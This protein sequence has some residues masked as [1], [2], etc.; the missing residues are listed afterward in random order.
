MYKH[1]RQ[2]PYSCIDVYSSTNIM[3]TLYIYMY[4]TWIM[5]ICIVSWCLRTSCLNY[6]VFFKWPI[7]GAWVPTCCPRAESWAATARAATPLGRCRCASRP[8]SPG[9]GTWHHQ[10]LIAWIFLASQYLGILL[11]TSCILCR[12]FMKF[13]ACGTFAGGPARART[14]DS[15]TSPTNY[16]PP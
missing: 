1:S 14:I 4:N 5:D 6:P 16:V 15:G 11:L 3:C 8:H 10:T 7:Q 13:H 12:N 2:L 9:P